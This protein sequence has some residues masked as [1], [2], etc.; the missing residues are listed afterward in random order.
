M[1]YSLVDSQNAS[2]ARVHQ[3]GDEQGKHEQQRLQNDQLT[4]GTLYAR[5]LVNEWARVYKL[6]FT[7]SH[8]VITMR[9]LGLLV[10]NECDRGDLG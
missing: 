7:S 9:V 1:T 8:G 4:T 3:K 6:T 10:T 5:D 2:S